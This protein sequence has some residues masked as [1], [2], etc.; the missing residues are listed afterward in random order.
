M[1]TL[2]EVDGIKYSYNGS[3]VWPRRMFEVLTEDCVCH[4]GVNHLGICAKGM[5][6]NALMP[7]L[8]FGG[9]R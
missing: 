2:L 1:A 9:A 6:W 8:R 7:V 4:H 3:N 5:R